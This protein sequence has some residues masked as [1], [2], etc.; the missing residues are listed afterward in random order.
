MKIHA[1]IDPLV[2]Q[3]LPVHLWLWKRFPA[4]RLLG[5]QAKTFPLF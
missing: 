2:Y 1:L 3:S 5:G 4:E